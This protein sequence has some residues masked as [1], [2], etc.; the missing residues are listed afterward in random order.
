VLDT[1]HPVR[2]DMSETPT[3]VHGWPI[4]VPV[5]TYRVQLQPAFG[6]AALAAVVP[7][8]EALGVT[9]CYCSPYFKAR[10]GSTHGYDIGDHNALNPELGPQEAFEGL[11]ARLADHGMGHVL[12]F[13]PNHMGIDPRTNPWWRDVLE[14]GSSSVFAAYFDIDWEPIKTELR[15]KV[16][17][18][19]LSH[20]YGEA[21]ESGEIRLSYV[22]GTL[23]VNCQDRELPTN[24]RETVTVF[25]HHIDTLL[26]EGHK[27]DP[28]IQEFLSIIA[29]LQ[30]LPVYTDRRPERAEDRRREAAIARG[31][32]VRLTERSTA[33]GAR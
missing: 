22:A 5:S 13:V 2:E 25:R 16:L 26:V 1:R 19:I 24:A 8:L 21:L 18:P 20:Q 27:D 32:L 15:N 10:P 17:L 9:E 23:V 33:C 3:G 6:F 29:Q 7:Y 14:N 11:L 30:N 12:D 4:R 28:D 31:R